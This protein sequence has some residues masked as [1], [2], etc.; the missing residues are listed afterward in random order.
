MKNIALLGII[1]YGIKYKSK[2]LSFSQAPT[3]QKSSRKHRVDPNQQ[4][5][6]QQ[7]NQHTQTTFPQ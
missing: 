7:I 5:V 3:Q 4:L 1:I 2:D 6:Q